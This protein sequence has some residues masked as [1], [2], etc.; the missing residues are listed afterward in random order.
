M[1][2]TIKLWFDTLKTTLTN[3]RA[4]A[5]FA[6]LY[7]VLLVTFYIFIATREATVSQVL[8]T[9]VFLVL[10][11]AEFFVNQAA[12]VEYARERR[13]PWRQIVRDAIKFAVVTIPIILLGWGLWALLNKWQAH[14]PAPRP[15]FALAQNAAP[16]QPIHWPTLLFATLRALVFGVLLPLAAIELW[17]EVAGRNLK[18]LMGGGAKTIGR[19]IV[20][21]LSRTFSADS[22]FTY[23]LGMILFFA[24]PYWVLLTN[25]SAKGTKTDFAIFVLRVALVFAFTLIGWVVTIAA[26]ARMYREPE[27]VAATKPLPEATAEAA[28]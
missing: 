13:F 15:T 3:I 4:L 5:L 22:V 25:I 21:A 7:G 24:L 28:A 23:A 26:L 1:T 2:A 27:P 14:F 8:I 11:P 12:I 16:R 10:V 6:V 18:T 19:R 20:N 9:Y 17:I